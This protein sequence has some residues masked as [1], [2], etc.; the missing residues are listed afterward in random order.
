MDRVAA[1]WRTGHRFVPVPHPP[2]AAT[3]VGEAITTAPYRHHA[4]IAFPLTAPEELARRVPATVGVIQ[5][6]GES[7]CVLTTGANELD[8]LAGHLVGLD[9]DFEV[10]EPPELRHHLRTVASRLDRAASGS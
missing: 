5:P 7:G 3:L 1:A 6:D 9:L 4:V 8:I 10:R 2:D